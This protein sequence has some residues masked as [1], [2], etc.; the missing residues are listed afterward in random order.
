MGPVQTMLLDL[1]PLNCT[2][3]HRQ[4]DDAAGFPVPSARTVGWWPLDSP[5]AVP[6]PLP[7]H[8]QRERERGRESGGRERCK[9][10]ASV[11]HISRLAP[12]I[13]IILTD[14]S[15]LT[16]LFVNILLLPQRVGKVERTRP[17]WQPHVSNQESWF[18]E[19]K[20][21]DYAC[22]VLRALRKGFLFSEL[23]GASPARLTGLA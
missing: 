7:P 19:K 4:A 2:P 3:A 16:A 1:A 11:M 12:Y 20:R 13:R 9:L 17:L 10:R 6:L 8:P 15:A 23:A 22:Q 21:K 18:K 14:G 5:F